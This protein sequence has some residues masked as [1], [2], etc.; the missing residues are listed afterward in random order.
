MAA[1]LVIVS[2][3]FELAPADATEF[4]VEGPGSTWMYLIEVS[5]GSFQFNEMEG[6]INLQSP[7][8]DTTNN[9]AIIV[10]DKGF[11]VRPSGGSSRAK[12]SMVPV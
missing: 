9:K 11:Y 1:N 4:K 8:Y 2:K 6:G 10:S 7:S 5:A 12:V 3:P